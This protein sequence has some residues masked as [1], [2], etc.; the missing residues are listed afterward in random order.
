M[1]LDPGLKERVKSL[2]GG[3]NVT[4]KRLET[5]LDEVE[6]AR[7][8]REG[9]PVEMDPPILAPGDVVTLAPPVENTGALPLAGPDEDG[10]P[11]DDLSKP[12]EA[13]E[14]PAMPLTVPAPPLFADP[15]K[16]LMYEMLQ[17]MRAEIAALRVPATEAEK[18]E[19]LMA[20]KL[21]AVAAAGSVGFTS[22]AS[23]P[24]GEWFTSPFG[25][26]VR[27]RI[28]DCGECTPFRVSHYWCVVCAGGPFHYKQTY[29]HGRKMWLAP[30]GAWGVSHELCSPT[31]WIQYMSMLGRQPGVNDMEPPRVVTEGGAPE[32]QVVPVGSD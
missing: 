27:M 2:I 19:A 13:P 21:P 4:K 15:E 6:Q 23:L 10:D 9:P 11:D 22:Q 20:G 25:P 8:L 7:L 24:R 18:N 31:C 14:R 30:G 16:Q 17:G 32:R 1:N 26:K 5:L 28:C 12:F 3:R 29:P